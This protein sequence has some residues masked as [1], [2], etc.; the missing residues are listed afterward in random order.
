VATI[1]K[2]DYSRAG[3]NRTR[4]LLDDDPPELRRAIARAVGGTVA[5]DAEVAAA[6]AAI[7]PFPAAFVANRKPSD[8]ARTSTTT[9]AVD[10]SLQVSLQAS[11]RYTVRG[12]I[13]FATAVAAGFRWSLDGPTVSAIDVNRCMVEPAATAFSGVAIDTAYTTV[14][15]FAVAATSAGIIR[16]EANILVGGSP[17]NF[18]FW[19]A[20]NTSSGSAATVL[21][22]SYLEV[23]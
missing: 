2:P 7:P 9:L 19:W 16:F 23:L 18:G 14:Q 1:G 22:G 4:P 10:P 5:T 17:G 13:R 15:A 3:S 12:V 8:T 6:I 21:A 11:T 20:Q